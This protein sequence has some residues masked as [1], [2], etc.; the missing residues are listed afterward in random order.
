MW[1]AAER[2]RRRRWRR[3]AASSTTRLGSSRS[4]LESSP[5]RGERRCGG[6]VGSRGGGD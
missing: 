3:S 4:R 5:L 2:T 6:R 1:F